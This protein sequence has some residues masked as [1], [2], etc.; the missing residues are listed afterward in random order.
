LVQILPSPDS[1]RIMSYGTPQAINSLEGEERP[2][3]FLAFWEVM[4]GVSS[5]QLGN[6]E[7]GEQGIN[8][9]YIL[10]LERAIRLMRPGYAP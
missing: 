3:I 4:W 8:D 6:T 9:L 5:E 2:K 10:P 7:R 1:V